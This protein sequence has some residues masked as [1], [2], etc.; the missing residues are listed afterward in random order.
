M[1]YAGALGTRSYAAPEILS[2]IRTLAES[3]HKSLSGKP[4]QQQQQQQQQEQCPKKKKALSACVSNYGM[5]ADAFSVGA[6]IRHMVTGVPPSENCEEYIAMKNHP[7]LKL[8][9]M[10][11]KF[12]HS[13]GLCQSSSSSSIQQGPSKKVYRTSYDLPACIKDLIHSLTYH[14][15][16]RRATVR[17]V[18]GHVW[19]RTTASTTTATM[20]TSTSQTNTP[21]ILFPE[22]EHGRPI[23][24]L[25]CGG[26]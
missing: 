5:V 3:M 12:C 7:L 11:I 21:T 2:G 25:D 19:I 13:K 22:V 8:G 16:R 14:D 1:V 18:T 20:E 23:V 17:S 24:Y 4:K 6:T 26:K 15:T 9:R 10:V